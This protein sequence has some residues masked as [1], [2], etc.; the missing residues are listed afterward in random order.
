MEFERQLLEQR[1][2]RE[3]TRTRTDIVNAYVKNIM[4]LPVITGVN[5]RKSEATTTSKAKLGHA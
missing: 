2:I 4:E 1:R 3:S 5:P